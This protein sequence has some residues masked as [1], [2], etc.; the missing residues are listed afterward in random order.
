MQFFLPQVVALSPDICA[1]HR[2][3]H[4][5]YIFTDTVDCPSDAG[6]G[7][8]YV[9]IMIQHQLCYLVRSVIVKL[10]TAHYLSGNLF[11][12]KGMFLIMCRP[13]CIHSQGLR[14]ANIMKKH[15]QP[16]YLIGFH[17]QHRMQNMFSHVIA[18]MLM[19][20]R[21]FHT[22]VKF[23]QNLRCNAKLISR[24]Q[25]IG[26]RRSHQLYQLH[27]NPLRTDLLQIGSQ[28]PD[29][30][31]GIFLNTITKLHAAY[32]VHLRQTALSHF[33]RSG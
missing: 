8:R 11:T 30:F 25:I 22:Q 14:F 9:I 21:R 28:S 29:R 23:R 6:L 12:F 27:L 16:Q 32:A 24:P 7:R 10:Q 5:E 18:M 13:V 17:P 3:Y 2:K 15:A 31:P 4:G 1:P 20:L 33:P 26:M 19:S